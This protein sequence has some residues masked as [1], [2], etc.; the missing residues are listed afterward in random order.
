MNPRGALIV[1]EG[2]DKSGKTTQCNKLFKIL[3][4]RHIPIRLLQFPNRE[5]AIG[6]IIHNYLQKKCE[7]ENHAIHLLFAANRWE[8]VP[9][10]SKLM[11][12]GISVILDR[13]SYSGI[14]FSAAKEN[15]NISWCAACERGLP[16]PDI[17]FF[18]KTH[19]V[20]LSQRNSFGHER[21]EQLEYQDTVAKLYNKLQDETWHIIDGNRSVQC[22]AKEIEQV[23]MF[24]L[25]QIKYQKVSTF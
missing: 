12:E 10:I 15:M 9:E 21:Y 13:Y 8:L 2:C 14:A 20:D 5:T 4:D 19:H 16:K 18:L 6:S 1:F 3:N 22:I 7:I 25:K 24:I 23:T 17:T 11:D